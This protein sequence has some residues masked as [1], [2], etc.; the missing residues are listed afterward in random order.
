M[1]ARL[2]R[3]IDDRHQW[4]T[5][6]LISDERISL[7]RRVF[8]CLMGLGRL[9]HGEAAGLRWRHVEPEI[10]P[11]GRL[12]IATSY[13]L[14]RTNTNT[15][16]PVP[17]HPTQAALLAEWKL[18]GWAA[19]MERMPEPDDLVVPLPKSNQGVLG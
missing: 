6:S 10:E 15:S 7:S 14:S 12:L 16:R 11:L 4:N 8:Y 13:D 17:I 3:G 18:S 9:R 1:P 5:H 2:H 19:L